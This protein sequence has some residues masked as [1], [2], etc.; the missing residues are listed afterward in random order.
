M[1]RFKASERGGNEG[2]GGGEEGA[3]PQASALEP[4]DRSQLVLRGRDESERRLGVAQQAFSGVGDAHRSRPPVDEREPELALERRDVVG[5]DRL[6]VPE[7]TRGR[8]KG[9]ASCD[10]VEGAQAAAIVHR[11]TA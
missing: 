10:G 8:G 4:G 2:V 9:T 7:L 1:Y 11:Q 6:R 5:D 3:D